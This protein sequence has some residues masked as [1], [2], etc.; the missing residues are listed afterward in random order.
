MR[1]L[2]SVAEI[3]RRLGAILPGTDPTNVGLLAAR[4]FA[5]MLYVNAVHSEHDDLTTEIGWAR[6]STVIWL[7]DDVYAHDDEASRKQ[8]SK[9][10]AR[11]RRQVE[12]LHQQWG[13]S[14]SLRWYADN[15]R[16][17]LRDETLP[18][19][20]Q[21]GG[22]RKRPNVPTNSS[23]PRWAMDDGFADLFNPA[24]QDDALRQA[25]EVWRDSHLSPGDRLRISKLAERA[26]AQHQVVVTLPDGVQRSLEPGDSSLIIRGVLEQWAPARLTDPVVLTISEP[27]AKVF[28]ADAAQLATLGIRIDPKTLLPDV[29]VADIGVKPT[30]FWIVEVCSSDGEINEARKNALL[31]WAALQRIPAELCSF[32]TAFYDRSDQV[33]RRHLKDLAVDSFAWFLTEPT[34]ELAW[35]EIENAD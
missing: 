31:D 9:A 4:T 15:T 18:H 30:R 26:L 19:W 33:A 8:W 7:S 10:A 23:K 29:V 22:V 5:A 3:Q 28:L 20:L 1:P 16:E 2:L 27:G 11:G 12:E 32:L 21:V 25:I 34:R 24:L 14:T 13:L 6:P 35:Q 17:T